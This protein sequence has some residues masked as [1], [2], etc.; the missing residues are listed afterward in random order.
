M[1]QRERLEKLRRLHYLLAFQWNCGIPGCDGAP[2]AGQPNRHARPDQLAPPGD[3]LVWLIQAGRGWGK[4]RVGAEWIKAR[5]L[6]QPGTRW[7]VVA[8][9]FGDAR[10]T[11]VEGE[12]GLLAVLPDDRVA[13]WNR[14]MGELFLANGSRIKCFSADEPERLRGPQ[15]H[16]AWCVAAEVPVV[17]AR[18]DVPIA[19]VRPGDFVLTRRG[20]RPV[21][22]AR[23]TKRDAAVVTVTTEAGRTLRCTPDHPVL[24]DGAW[25]DAETLSPGTTLSACSLMDRPPTGTG[26]ASAG[27][28]TTVPAGTAA[29]LASP[30]PRPSG[31]TSTAPSQTATTCTTSTETRPTTTRPTSA[32]SNDAA[33]AIATPPRTAPSRPAPP[34]APQR[35][36]RPGSRNSASASTAAH[37]TN[38]DR[39]TA[40]TAGRTAALE[41]DA[42]VS[43]R[44]SGWAD[45]YDL[46]VADAHEFYAGGVLVH[47]CDELAA[48]R[49]PDAWDQLQFGLRLGDMPR[50]VVTT[51]PKPTRLVKALAERT[52]VHVTRGATFDNAAN[53]SAAALAEL[54]ARYEGTR[55]GR[56]ELYGELLDDV[57]GALW[58]HAMIDDH[59]RPM[60][61]LVRVVTAIDPAVT[62]GEDSDET[63]IIVAGIGTDGDG[64]VVA[65]RS[66]KFT[67]DAWARRAVAAHDEHQGDRVVAEVNNGGDLVELT[68]RAVDPTVPYRK[69]TASRG[70]RLRAE[71]V[72]A[73][74]E[75]GRIHHVGVLTALE[76]QMLTW[77]PESGD[78]PDRLDALVWAL[79]DLMLT[80]SKA[81]RRGLIVRDAA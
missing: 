27:T 54:R 71:P 40:R 30:S 13:N 6:E 58:T 11:C 33:I 63:G 7:A 5:A 12:S 59:R 8:P 38:P 64:Y 74:Y 52:D 47:N 25:C 39:P 62:S 53:L 2:H 32:S 61:E 48:W 37:P 16:G 67:P 43:V 68:L 4:T 60:P 34:S 81:R 9:T 41:H 69:V 17:T 3:W 31:L 78:S 46:T 1:N 19:D 77:T 51:T 22:A 56:Q 42:V 57:E 44:P 49:Y 10:D 36:G 24:A 20:W 65:D 50:T 45:V 70:K 66:G 73:L 21:L 23:R 14:S 80:E 15:H 26:T 72:A 79:T 28:S 75:Q 29:P 35:C 76:E 55:M 18:G